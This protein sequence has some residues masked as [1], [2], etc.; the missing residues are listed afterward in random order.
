MRGFTLSNKDG[1]EVV[2]SPE[3]AILIRSPRGC[4]CD[5]D[6]MLSDSV[7]LR[8]LGQLCSNLVHHGSSHLT[9][10]GRVD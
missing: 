4:L 5:M 10:H 9:F 7:F 8:R 6:P 2:T 3:G 1:A